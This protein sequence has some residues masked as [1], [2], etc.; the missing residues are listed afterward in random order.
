MVTEKNAAAEGT[1]HRLDKELLLKLFN[2]A[3][4]R[5][6]DQEPVIE[7][8]RSSMTKTEVLAGESGRAGSQENCPPKIQKL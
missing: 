8:Q 5:Q 4:L 6:R 2:Q 3:S 7:G 1:S